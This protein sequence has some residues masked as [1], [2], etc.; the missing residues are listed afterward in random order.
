MG[1]TISVP[2]DAEHGPELA[3]RGTSGDRRRRPGG[4]GRA[5]TA[6]VATAKPL[7]QASRANE[8]CRQDA[9]QT[10]VPSTC[11]CRSATAPRTI[12]AKVKPALTDLTSPQSSS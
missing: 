1:R 6:I 4:L 2:V 3:S 12:I 10:T 8:A 5:R 9:W 7:S 11:R